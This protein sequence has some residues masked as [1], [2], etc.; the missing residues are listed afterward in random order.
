MGGG[1]GG[2]RLKVHSPLSWQQMLIYFVLCLCLFPSPF[3][4][5]FEE[6]TLIYI[7]NADLESAFVL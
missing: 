2:E 3:N 5:K 4:N 6:L 7:F 1:G